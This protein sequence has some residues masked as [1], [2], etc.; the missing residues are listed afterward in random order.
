M[1]LTFVLIATPLLSGAS[2]A[3]SSRFASFMQRANHYLDKGDYING[4]LTLEELLSSGDLENDSYREADARAIL[5]QALMVSGKPEEGYAQLN[6]AMQLVPLVNNLDKREGARI[7]AQIY[8]GWGIYFFTVHGD[9]Y[10]AKK[11]FVKAAKTAIDHDLTRMTHTFET[12]IVQCALLERDASSLN[13]AK[14]LFLWAS[15]NND[16]YTKFITSCQLAQF[17]VMND[18]VKQASEYLKI[19]ESLW[20]KEKVGDKIPL[21][22]AKSDI[23]Q[24]QSRQNEALET[25]REAFLFIDSGNESTDNAVLIQYR[26]SEILFA[27]GRFHDAYSS[28]LHTLEIADIN[29]MLILRPKILL[30]ASKSAEMAGDTANTIKYARL[31]EEYQ[32]SAYN[33]SKESLTQS[34]NVAYNA[35][36]KEQEIEYANSML[37]KVRQ[38]NT[39]L[40]IS[41]IL[42]IL[43]VAGSIG[44]FLYKSRVYR[45]LASLYQEVIRKE[46]ENDFIVMNE[47]KALTEQN[48]E[49]LQLTPVADESSKEIPDPKLN[50]I[51]TGLLEFLANSDDWSDSTMN[52]DAISARLETNHTY[53]SK[54]VKD[55]TGMSF[56]Q[57]ITHRR[58]TKAVEI[59]SD[60][61]KK[62]Y[63]LKNLS[64]DLGFGSIAAFYSNFKAATGMSPAAFRKN[65]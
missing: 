4:I 23:L 46:K 17:Y 33:L 13:Q 14:K 64:S 30:L 52:R 8:N 54:I 25:L 19:A 38:R 15:D 65:I 51:W 50:R 58:I 44:A 55:K 7:T 6:H 2:D 41:V 5:G 12:N 57:F 56:S 59:L 3:D 49:N 39:F 48:T 61:S 60:P 27:M 22:L 63:P 47:T 29:N 20:S 31:Y 40:V 24:A 11:Y 16:F 21:Y 1:I 28:A 18:D 36:K 43:I 26:I 34:L 62:D 35:E 32:D 45:K 42:L 37:R 10:S 53:L 9:Y